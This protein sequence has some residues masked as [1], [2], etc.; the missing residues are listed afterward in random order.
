[1]PVDVPGRGRAPGAGA[2]TA[3]EARAALRRVGLEPVRIEAITGGWAHWTFE[4]DGAVIVRFPR[5][6]SVALATHREL[7]LL[8]ELAGFVSFAVPTPERVASLHDRPFFTYQRIPGRPLSEGGAPAALTALGPM[9][10]ELHRFPVDRAAHLLRL[11]PPERVWQDRYEDLWETISLV[12]LPV[13]PADLADEVRRSYASFVERPPA[14]PVC[15]IH[16]DLGPEHVL[17]DPSTGGP[18]GLIDFEDASVG[19]PAVDLAPLAAAL[20]PEA[21]PALRHGRDLGERLADRLRF[22][23]WVGSLHAIIYGVTAG[24]EVERVGGIRELRQR[25]ER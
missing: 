20:G 11:G 24:V 17:L 9:L 19:D 1:M 14:F 7:V 13:L 8:P 15:L 4:L 12:A 5:N 21:L 3:D 10:H 6:D 23:R 16:N 22:Y 25:I 2:V 18:T